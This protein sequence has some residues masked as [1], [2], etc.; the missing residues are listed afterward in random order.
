M[1]DMAITFTGAWR[2]NKIG[3]IIAH[4]DDEAGPAAQK[5]IATATA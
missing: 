4:L 2:A 5:K 3:R 1:T